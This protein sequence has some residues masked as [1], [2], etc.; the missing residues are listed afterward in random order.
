MQL[1]PERSGGG[2]AARAPR[3]ARRPPHVLPAQQPHLRRRPVGHGGQPGG[4]VW[5]DAKEVLSGDLQQRELAQDE[6]APQVEGKKV[7]AHSVLGVSMT[8]STFLSHH[9][10]KSQ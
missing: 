5:S 10:T 6:Q 1:L 8:C 3:D 2:G 7:S 4:E 9:F